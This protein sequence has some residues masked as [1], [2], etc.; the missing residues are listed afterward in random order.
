MKGALTD[1][2]RVEEL[3]KIGFGPC[4]IEPVSWVS[5]SLAKLLGYRFIIRANFL[6]DGVTGSWLWYGDIVLVSESLELRVGPAI[7]ASVQIV[8][9]VISSI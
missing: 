3:L 8:N 1:S 6:K 5:G 4:F 7:F 2:V 9:E